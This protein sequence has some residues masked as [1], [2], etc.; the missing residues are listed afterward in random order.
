MKEGVLYNLSMQKSFII[1]DSFLLIWKVQRYFKIKGPI[2]MHLTSRC[3]FGKT[4]IWFSKLRKI[5]PDENCKKMLAH[6]YFWC[7]IF[8]KTACKFQFRF[9]FGFWRVVRKFQ[10]R[11]GFWLWFS[12][13]DSFSVSNFGTTF[14]I[15]GIPFTICFLDL[16]PT[17]LTLPEVKMM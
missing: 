17:M 8:W 2:L 7:C 12:N 9:E 3:A 11:F 5:C 10:F 16:P 13:P 1:L 4:G 6:G 14:L 15:Q